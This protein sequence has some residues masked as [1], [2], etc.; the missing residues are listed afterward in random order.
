MHGVFCT[1]SRALEERSN[2]YR[3]SPKA[4]TTSASLTLA[5]RLWLGQLP[6]S[7]AILITFFRIT[8]AQ[9]LGV[10][11]GDG[12]QEW[13]SRHRHLHFRTSPLSALTQPPEPSSQS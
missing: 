13:W 6:S 12:T 1:P 9:T 2:P 10:E 5:S 11:V 8:E 7:N 4:L 3:R